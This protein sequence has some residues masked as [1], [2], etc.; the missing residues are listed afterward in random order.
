[1][2]VT[3]M[4]RGWALFVLVVALPLAGC[5][6]SRLSH[7]E[8]MAM[9]GVGATAPQAAGAVADGGAAA[10]SGA[11]TGGGGGPSSTVSGAQGV[12][13]QVAPA[14]GAGTTIP[15]TAAS[16]HAAAPGET[17]A[18]S[19]TTGVSP[20][21]PLAPILLGNVG[22]YSGPAGSSLAGAGPET[23]VWAAWVN[24]HGGIAG[25]PVQVYTADD[26]ADPAKSLSIIKDMV[27]SRHVVAFIGNETIL[28][29]QAAIGYL[30]QH[31]VPVVGGDATET[32]W[33]SS[34]V[35]FPEG[36]TNFEL[37]DALAKMVRRSGL[38]KVA[39]LYCIEATQCQ[40]NGKYVL[41]QGAAKNGVQIVYSSQVSI[42][43]PDFTPQCLGASS[44]G[45]QVIW[46]IVDSNSY[47]RLAASCH[48]QGI[49]AQYVAA[50]LVV[51]SDLADD[52]DLDGMLAS[53][54]TFPWVLGDGPAAAAYQQANQQ[55]A[56][57]LILSSAASIS[58]SS[59][60]LLAR[61]L[62]HLGA[63]QPT[64]DAVLHGLWSLRG[65]TLGGLVPPLTFTAN[66]PAPVN[67]CYFVMAIHG[68]RW[69]APEGDHAE[70]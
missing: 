45:A 16:S 64:S 39:L 9:A 13:G 15:G 63:A 6:G 36:T 41:D 2:E 65:E 59:G 67:P 1:V 23:Q 37:Y 14:P 66:K 48:R 58:W 29:S 10:G 32:A 21:G 35:L 17:G 62:A 56:P 69:T 31:H 55:Y 26:G 25:H 53:V 27:E 70:C 50:Q 40:T 24:A 52:P 22:N 60:Q 8:L 68:G 43:Q 38:T 42:T 18:R 47:R 57:N 44:S 51:T 7:A 34:P 49:H 20:A 19:S 28:T 61:A 11:S 5:G 33:T 54:P 3:V 4:R 12:P 30:E 46:A